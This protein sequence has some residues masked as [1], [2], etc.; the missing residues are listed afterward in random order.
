MSRLPIIKVYPKKHPRG[1]PLQID[2]EKVKKE[3]GACASTTFS[4]RYG[5]E[6]VAALTLKRLVEKIEQTEQIRETEKRWAARR[7]AERRKK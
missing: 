2:L 4:H 6:G 3:A 5:T 1:K 7:N